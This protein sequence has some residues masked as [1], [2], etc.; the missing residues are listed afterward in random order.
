MS[1]EIDRS[2]ASRL[3]EQV[4]LSLTNV[5]VQIEKPRGSVQL[6]GFADFQL[7]VAGE[8]FLL[9]PSSAIKTI[10]GQIHFDP[11]AEKARKGDAEVYFPVWRPLSAEARAVLT[12]LLADCPE[13]QEMQRQAQEKSH[14]V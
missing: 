14:A 4:Q 13:V 8:P 5:R 3:W 7:F 6:L 12:R 11:K 1:K 2:V 10:R 9:L